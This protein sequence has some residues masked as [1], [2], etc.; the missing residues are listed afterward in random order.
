MASIKFSL[1]LVGDNQW[2][3]KLGS[4]KIISE[5]HPRWCLVLTSAARFTGV[6]C[7]TISRAALAIFR[8]QDRHACSKGKA[9]VCT[10]LSVNF[11]NLEVT[12]NS[13]LV[14]QPD[15]GDMSQLQW[16]WLYLTLA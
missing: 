4:I 5:S 12:L 7:G 1:V 9:M 15:A 6:S 11:R 3:L 16:L 8:T 13:C 10:A 2:V 14:A